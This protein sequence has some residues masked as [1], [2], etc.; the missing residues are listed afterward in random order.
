MYMNYAMSFFLFHLSAE[1]Y[2]QTCVHTLQCIYICIYNVLAR[3]LSIIKWQNMLEVKYVCVLLFGLMGHW[4]RSHNN[5]F[6]R[7]V[8]CAWRRCRC[9]EKNKNRR[10]VNKE[11]ISNFLY[12]NRFRSFFSGLHQQ[13]IPYFRFKT[14]QHAA[15]AD[16]LGDTEE[17]NGRSMENPSDI[18]YSSWQRELI[19]FIGH[20]IDCL[21]LLALR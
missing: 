21:N 1:A 2:V 4:L 16:I 20:L 8:S 18:E 9:V 5:S 13:A 15:N 3:T 12:D 7:R 17:I 10:N 11:R 6:V 19:F 14:Q